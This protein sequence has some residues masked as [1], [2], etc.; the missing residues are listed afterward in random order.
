MY[1][2]GKEQRP[3]RVEDHFSIRVPLFII[4]QIAR[5]GH[6]GAAGGER[7][8][9]DRAQV[10]GSV[11]RQRDHDVLARGRDVTVDVNEASLPGRGIGDG[12]GERGG[13]RGTGKGGRKGGA[14]VAPAK[15]P[16]PGRRHEESRER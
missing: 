6:A 5:A 3:G 7:R 13:E 9:R 15:G 14:A 4:Q 1:I 2:H 11:G 16:A 8:S 12:A 10:A